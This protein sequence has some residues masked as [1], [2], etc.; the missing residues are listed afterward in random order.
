M[1]SRKS[2]EK[3]KRKKK[4]TR[5]AIAKLFALNANT[6]KNL[7]EVENWKHNIVS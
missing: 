2:D 1:L 3:E 7:F 6:I 5:K 4:T